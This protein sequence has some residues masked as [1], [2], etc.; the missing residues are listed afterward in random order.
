MLLAA[1]CSNGVRPHDDARPYS[2]AATTASSAPTL[3]DVLCRAA[4]PDGD[5][6][7]AFETTVGQVRTRAYGPGIR[8]AASAWPDRSAHAPAVWCYVRAGGAL[9]VAGAV[10]G[11]EPVVF[12]RGSFPI[13]DQGPLFP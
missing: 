5:V 13:S 9:T 1:A 11:A 6:A 12:A 4:F 7:G 3:A 8:P 10:G 2:P